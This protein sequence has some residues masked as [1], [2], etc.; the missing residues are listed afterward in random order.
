LNYEHS[1]E[2]NDKY[3]DRTGMMG[4]S[5]SN[6]NG[7]KMCFNSVKSWQSGWYGIN[8]AFGDKTKEIFN[9]SAECLDIDLYGI[10]GYGDLAASVVLVKFTVRGSE[11]FVTYNAA[12]G[13][14]SGTLEA[15]NEVTVTTID[16]EGRSLLLAQLSAGQSWSRRNM[17]VNVISIDSAY[18]RVLISENGDPCGPTTSPTT[19]PPSVSPTTYS[20]TFSSEPTLSLL[21]LEEVGNDGQPYPGYP[22]DAFPLKRCQADCDNDVSIYAF[23]V[24][25]LCHL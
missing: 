5:Y 3:N 12:Y 15:A 19:S 11:Y 9:N 2:G 1:G 17:Q 4:Y 21:P 24:E 6:L 14:S 18:A 25:T 22:T 7:P 23:F 10:A 16:A 13:I 8:G 20:P